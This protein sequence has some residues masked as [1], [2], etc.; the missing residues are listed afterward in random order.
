MCIGITDSRQTSN[1]IGKM[2]DLLVSFCFTL[3][4]CFLAFLSLHY[5]TLEV[6]RCKINPHFQEFWNTLKVAVCFQNSSQFT[7]KPKRNILVNEYNAQKGKYLSKDLT[8]RTA[9]FS[10]DSLELVCNF[11]RRQSISW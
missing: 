4:S 1:L 10:L 2:L 6:Q 3:L 11:S 9:V 5:F 8:S 7:M